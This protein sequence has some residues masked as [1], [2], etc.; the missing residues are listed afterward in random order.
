[1]KHRPFDWNGDGVLDLVQRADA[2][3]IYGERILSGA[4]G[5]ELLPFGPPR[6]VIGDVNGDLIPEYAS[7]LPTP[8][9]FVGPAGPNIV[10][11]SVH[12]GVSGHG[13]GSGTLAAGWAPVPAAPTQGHVVLNGGTPGGGVAIAGSL[14]P[15]TGTI[16]P[17]GAPLLIDPGQIVFLADVHLDATGS[18][19][20]YA[21]LGI[22]WLA[23]VIVYYQ[24]AEYVSG[25]TSNGFVIR[26]DA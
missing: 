3:G 17:I 22:P 11:V 9:G 20:A 21:N 25:E 23:G 1:M 10:R 7:I 12:K 18:Y 13:A 26:F 14:A 5:G 24:V 4:D 19:M 16:G 8:A 2:A 15:T 6:T